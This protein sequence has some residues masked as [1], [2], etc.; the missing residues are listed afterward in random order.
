MIRVLLTF[1]TVLLVALMISLGFWQLDRAEQKNTL[2]RDFALRP[3]KKPLTLNEIHPG[4]DVRYYPIKLSGYYD[5]AHSILLDNKIYNQQVGY[6]VLTPFKSI[7]SQTQ[8]L[9]NRGWVSMGTSRRELP[10]IPPIAGKQ[11]ITGILYESTKKPFLLQQDTQQ[12]HW[13]LLIQAIQIDQLAEQLNTKLY[14]FIVLLSPNANGGFV[15]DWQPATIKPAKH[16]GYAVQW[17]ALAA[18]LVIIYLVLLVRAMR[19]KAH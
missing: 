2:N 1:V 13:P 17:F 16:L 14:P 8:V 6:Q 15:R 11:T 4:Q 5:N 7:N 9:V 19:T 10:Q 12:S 18:T 3:L